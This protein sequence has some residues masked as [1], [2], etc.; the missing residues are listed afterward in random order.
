MTV[1]NVGPD[2]RATTT[3]CPLSAPERS[4]NDSAEPQT[5]A[6]LSTNRRRLPPNQDSVVI[7]APTYQVYSIEPASQ[8]LATLLSFFGQSK[9]SNYLLEQA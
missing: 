1:A 8:A 9:I 6:A 7:T 4:N 2:E 5:G 3:N